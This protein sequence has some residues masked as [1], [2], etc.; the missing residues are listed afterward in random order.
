LR[1][2]RFGSDL[3]A[4]TVALEEPIACAFEL[5][6]M[7]GCLVAARR[8]PSPFALQAP[9]LGLRHLPIVRIG[10]G[11]RRFAERAHLRDAL[12]PPFP[13]HA[14]VGLAAREERVGR[15]AKAFQERRRKTRP[16]RTDLFPLRLQPLKRCS[17]GK[18]VGGIGQAFGLGTKRLFLGEVVGQIGTRLPVQLAAHGAKSL[19]QHLRMLLRHNSEALPV[20][21]DLDALLQH[22]FRISGGEQCFGPLDEL[23]LRIRVGPT[24]PLFRRLLLRG[25]AH[26][27]LLRVV[28]TLAQAGTL[29]RRQI[30]QPW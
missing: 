14:Q 29:Q 25:A 5:V 4:T 17:G 10:H 23:L 12:L 18:P 15:S 27:R 6:P 30:A 11:R 8:H 24:L 13:A 26:E 3:V 20:A 22:T 21:I 9:N 16:N 28:E 19:P 2:P 1:E 7:S